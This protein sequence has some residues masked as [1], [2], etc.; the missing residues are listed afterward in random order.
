M[1]MIIQATI[2]SFPCSSALGLI[3]MMQFVPST[4]RAFGACRL[5]PTWKVHTKRT[6]SAS[7]ADVD[8]PQK[9]VALR[10]RK[11]LCHVSRIVQLR[12]LKRLH[13]KLIA[14]FNLLRFIHTSLWGRGQPRAH[15]AHQ[16]VYIKLFLG[17]IFIRMPATSSH[18]IFIPAN[19]VRLR[20]ACSRPLPRSPLVLSFRI[21]ASLPAMPEYADKTGIASYQLTSSPGLERTPLGN[22]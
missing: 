17:E 19:L 12:N 1:K 10:L 16:D 21:S 7:Y 8:R 14:C 15:K 11:A 5:D 2:A 6:W 9:V 18:L 3:A 22:A 13:S 4:S 20:F